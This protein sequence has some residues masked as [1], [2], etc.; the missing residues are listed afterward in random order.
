MNEK[1]RLQFLK[2]E[3]RILDKEIAEKQKNYIHGAE[4]SSLKKRKLQIKDEIKKLMETPSNSAMCMN[5]I[6]KL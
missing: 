1:D 3:H 2:T 6:T 4:L 5:N